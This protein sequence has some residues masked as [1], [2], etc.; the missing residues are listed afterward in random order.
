MFAIRNNPDITHPMGAGQ[1]YY[2]NCPAPFHYIAH[3]NT[4]YHA[5][6]VLT[7]LCHTYRVQT[8][9]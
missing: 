3:I 2:P 5:T 9:L 8:L 4:P 6:I 7:P 1:P